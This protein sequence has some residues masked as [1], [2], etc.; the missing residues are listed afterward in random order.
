M[1]L[2]LRMGLGS[3][4]TMGAASVPSWSYPGGAY[5]FARST[6][7]LYQ[8]ADDDWISAAIDELRFDADGNTILEEASTNYIRDS[9]WSGAI[10]GTTTFG[11]TW[12]TTPS[13]MT[14]LIVTESV[15]NGLN[16]IDVRF[17][18]AGAGN[19]NLRDSLASIVTVAQGDIMTGTVF[20]AI[21]G[22]STTNVSQVTVRIAGRNASDAETEGAATNF[23]GSLTADLQRFT[24]TH[25]FAVATTAKSR[26]EMA[27][28]AT[29]ACDITIRYAAPQA[30]LRATATTPIV[31]TGAAGTRADDLLTP[32][33]PVGPTNDMIVT[34]DDLSETVLPDVTSPYTIDPSTLDR[35]LVSS[36]D[37]RAV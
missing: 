14:R 12:S 15:V 10:A 6:V 13:S 36:I 5:G 22:G 25:T 29:G 3:L 20:A 37:W 32:T 16:C 31:T 23:V 35:P 17:T 27:V 11:A 26:M 21:V 2:S 4:V 1:D 28:V 34:H 9:A 18:S 19:H 33:L 7:A 30:E 8:D 24:K